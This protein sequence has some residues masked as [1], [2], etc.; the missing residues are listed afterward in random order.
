SSL[1]LGIPSLEV[2]SNTAERRR[3]FALDKPVVNVGRDVTNDVVMDDQC[4]SG[5]HLQ[6]VREGQQ[7]I[8]LHPHPERQQTA[9]GLLY[10]G[11]KIRGDEL[12]RK[13]LAEGD[14][15]RISDEQGTLVTLTYH[16]GSSSHQEPM[17]P[18]RPIRLGEA[19]LTIGRKEDN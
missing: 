14:V 11:G 4:V 18:M 19:E 2:S 16:D 17:P 13:A 5:L 1:M 10:Q 3:N 9:H 7:L 15:F 12:Y 8:L 6:I